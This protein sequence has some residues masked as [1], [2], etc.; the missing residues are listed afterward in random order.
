VR[1]VVLDGRDVTDRAFDIGAGGASGLVMTFTD[2]AS[3][4]SGTITTASGSPAT[5]YF[6]IAIPADRAQWLPQSR[7]IVSARPDRSGRY[8]FTRLPAGEYRIAI[9]SDLVPRDLQE[10]SA[11][12]RLAAQSA[13]VSIA[14]GEKKVLDLRAGGG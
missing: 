6:V 9:T 2:L 14:T 5:D 13:P 11:L 10:V 3:E 1:S 7:R 4:L 12:E 8:V